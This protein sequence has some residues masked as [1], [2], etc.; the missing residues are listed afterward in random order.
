MFPL[1]WAFCELK[2]WGDIFSRVFHKWAAIFCSFLKSHVFTHINARRPGY[3]V[4]GRKIPKNTFHPPK[5]KK[6]SLKWNF[7]VASLFK[8]FCMPFHT[9]YKFSCFYDEMH[10]SPKFWIGKKLPYPFKVEQN[11]FWSTRCRSAITRAQ[12]TSIHRRSPIVLRSVIGK[13]AL[14]PYRCVGRENV[15]EH[16]LCKIERQSFF[17]PRFFQYLQ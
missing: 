8:L 2:S 5:R 17:V 7:C 14:Q 9:Y 6:I 3:T 13:R 1:R 11:A 10:D 4:L 16:F 12:T 15:K